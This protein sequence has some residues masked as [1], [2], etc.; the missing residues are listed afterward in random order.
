MKKV[1]LLLIVL[2]PALTPCWSQQ[3]SLHLPPVAKF[4]L[5]AAVPAGTHTPAL[6]KPAPVRYNYYN[7]LGAACKA[8]FKLEKATRVPLRIRL[9][10][11]A[12]TD[13]M[14]QKPHA[15]RP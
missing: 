8:E 10:S 3:D 15:T 11:L 1:L 6:Q 14:E 9:G 13:Y 2:L 12:Q 7:S 5:P 4:V